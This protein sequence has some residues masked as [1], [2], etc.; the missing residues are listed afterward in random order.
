MP[1]INSPSRKRTRAGS[2]G[3]NAQVGISGS[4]WSQS[5]YANNQ[6]LTFSWKTASLDTGY[7]VKQVS[8]EG[9]SRNA[10]MDITIF[11]SN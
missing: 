6:V 10:G 7:T 9:F 3:G 2:V 5:T 1:P 11:G 8:S 4:G